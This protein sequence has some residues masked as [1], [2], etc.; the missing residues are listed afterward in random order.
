MKTDRLKPVQDRARLRARTQVL[1]LAVWLSLVLALLTRHV[2]WRDE[3][4][5]LSLALQGEGVLGMLRG[6]HG[7]GHPAL[8]YLLLRAGATVVPATALLPVVSVT[9]AVAAMVLLV[10]RS[11]FGA[12]LVGVFMLGRPA[13]YEYSVM[14]RNYG[15][16]M[17]LMFAFA[18]LYER[19]R[20]RGV[21][22]GVVLALLANCNVHSAILAGALSLFWLLDL[23][24]RGAGLRAGAWRNFWVNA[25]LAVLGVVVCAATI[26]PP[27]N[28][29]ARVD[30]SGWS[31]AALAKALMLP[32][33]GFPKLSGYPVWEAGLKSMSLLHAPQ[34]LAVHVAMSLLLV[35]SVLGLAARPAAA[36]AGGVALLGLSVFFSLIYGGD[37]RHQALWLVFL[38][39]L[40]WIADASAPASEPSRARLV[41]RRAGFTCFCL[42]LALQVALGA[43]RVAAMTNVQ[44]PESRSRD[45][46]RLVASRPELRDAIIVADPDYLVES[47]AHYLPNRIYLLRE[48]RF[49]NVVMFTR[50]ARL[51]L[52]L[53]EV[54]A[55]ARR[56]RAETQRPVIILLAHRLD[57]AAPA[58]AATVTEGYNWTFSTTPAQVADF[59]SATR[60][61][62]SF[63]PVC[64]TD[65]TF[66]VH[67]LDR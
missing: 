8:W 17:L 4:R 33:M 3:V 35:G 65:E 57:A 22:L 56:L 14:A 40:Y 51:A 34:V 55:D 12:V 37:Y 2:V 53:D 11:P 63:G 16:A 23:R 13:L 30:A 25:A 58:P 15:I 10:R 32:S 64:C 18:A 9:V 49:G 60:R 46:V 43:S 5:A 21:A 45:L 36:I 42:L 50:K 48:Q 52:G 31:L 24:W 47:V 19:H 67:L 61:L 44:A 66:D 20:D 54:L 59:L 62:A 28:D 38:V 1:L 39:S 6:L 27:F 41:A 26:Y 29:A 7:E